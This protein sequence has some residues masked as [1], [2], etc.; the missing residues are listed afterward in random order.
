[1]VMIF[2]SIQVLKDAASASIY[3][4]RAANGVIIITT[5]QGKKGQ[6][7]INFDAS[8][9]AS[10]Y[11]SKMNVLNTEQCGRAMWQAYVNDGENPNGNALGYAYN[12]DR[13]PTAIRYYTE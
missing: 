7:K 6:I 3:G 10:M 9:S 4:S 8:V 5:K 1:M 13:M 11:Q 2:E 12:W